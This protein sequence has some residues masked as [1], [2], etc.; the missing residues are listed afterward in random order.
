MSLGFLNGYASTFA[1]EWVLVVQHHETAWSYLL[2]CQ[3]FSARQRTCIAQSHH[4]VAL[5]YQ[6]HH[7][8]MAV[9]LTRG[10]SAI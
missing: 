1:V 4:G 3:R 8:R 5:G 10:R 7:T 9:E 6:V 2:A